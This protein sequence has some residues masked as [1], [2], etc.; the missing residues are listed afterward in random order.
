MSRNIHDVVEWLA[1]AAHV[2][3]PSDLRDDYSHPWCRSR[4]SQAE[5][6]VIADGG[7]RVSR[8]F[9]QMSVF[10]TAREFGL[11][12][13]RLSMLQHLSRLSATALRAEMLTSPSVRPIHLVW[14]SS[15]ARVLSRRSGGRHPQDPQQARPPAEVSSGLELQMLQPDKP[16]I[17]C[18][19]R[20]SVCQQTA[21]AI[22]GQIA[23]RATRQCQFK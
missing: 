8:R 12:P 13:P 11:I 16:P 5:H 15:R 21:S 1:C 6:D 23:G 3:R 4:G 2:V 7:R 9:S 20:R 14:S 19:Y 10:A 17:G 22:G 18:G